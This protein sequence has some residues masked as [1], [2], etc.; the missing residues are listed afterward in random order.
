MTGEWEVIT[1]VVDSGAID[2]V[3]DMKTATAFPLENTPGS[4]RG[5]V[6][7]SASGNQIPQRGIRKVEGVSSDGLP[8]KIGLNVT[9][10][11][12]TLF[13][14]RKI[15]EAG[16]VVIFGADE[17]NFIINK[18]TGSCTPIKDDGHSYTMDVYVPKGAGVPQHRFQIGRKRKRYRDTHGK[19]NGWR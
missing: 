15:A 8:M 16:N 10:V 5:D 4:I 14:V 19:L 7:T 6:Y 3:T 18:Q 1:G 9:D 12:S 17:G 11:V 13:S 2:N